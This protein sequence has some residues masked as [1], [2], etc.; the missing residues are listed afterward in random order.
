M[1]DIKRASLVE[2]T[3]NAL[4]EFIDSDE[5]QIG[6][7]MP[8]EAY[9]CTKYKVSRTTIR[10]ALRFL[11]AMGYVELI[12]N[13]GAHVT[14]KQCSNIADSR[15]WIS[16]HAREV[17][18]VMEAR[19]AFEPCAASFAAL[20][21]TQTERYALMGLKTLFDDAVKQGNTSAMGMYDEKLHVAII[22]ASHNAFFL[23]I[24]DVISEALRGFRSRT[25]AVAQRCEIVTDY[26]DKIVEA[27]VNKKPDEAE[28]YMRGHMED[29]VQHMK[30]FISD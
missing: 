20:R 14:N 29:S 1:I 6:E 11:Q 4:K 23:E 5:I 10:E 25:F 12:P 18:D 8:S 28:K 13:K 22:T 24:N 17:L 7:K 19:F 9:L 27:I 3:T 16:T 15:I 30:T 2:Q 26:H 21:A